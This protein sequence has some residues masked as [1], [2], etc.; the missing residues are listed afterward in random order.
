MPQDLL[1]RHEINPSHDPATGG[2]MPEY[3]SKLLGF[4]LYGALVNRCG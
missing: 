2:G 1:D 3:A 4:R